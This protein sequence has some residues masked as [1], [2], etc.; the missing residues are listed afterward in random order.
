MS[1]E[2]FQLIYQNIDLPGVGAS[3]T[4]DAVEAA[5]DTER[6]TGHVP[7][8]TRCVVGVDLAGAG[9]GAGYTSMTV[10][11]VEV[12][13]G[14]RYLVDW[15]NERSMKAPRIRDVLLELCDTYPVT[16]VR[17][18]ANSLQSQILQYNEELTRA[19]ALKGIR[20]APHTTGRNKWD[21]NFGVE[22]LGPLF[23]TGLV[24]VPWRMA[25]DRAKFAPLLEQFIAFPLGA[26]NDGVMSFWIAD[27]GCRDLIRRAS[28]PLFYEGIRVP[29]RIR[30]NRVVVDFANREVVRV[31]L[32]LQRTGRHF[33]RRE[34]VGGVPETPPRP[35]LVTRSGW[36]NATEWSAED[37]FGTTAERIAEPDDDI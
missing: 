34:I 3:F 14:K 30:R 23:A 36:V 6:W 37:L 19:L 35:D 8:G 10:L 24:S 2:Q 32:H 4:P 31:P 11:A 22:T 18:E 26:T 9:P 1:P 29:E 27:L 33:G 15:H 13:T 28:L 20:L 16:E 12:A 17:V 5:K 21:P 7:P 25:R